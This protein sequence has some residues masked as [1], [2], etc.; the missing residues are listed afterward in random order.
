MLF[1]QP[2]DRRDIGATIS[3]SWFSANGKSTMS[4]LIVNLL[5]SALRFPDRVAVRLD[6][7]VL[8]YAQLGEHAARV[9]A[10]LR[11][12]GVT[13]GSRVPMMLP[14]VPEFVVLYCGNLRAGCVVVPMNPLLKTREVADYL[15]NA[16]ARLLFDR[17]DAAL[18]LI[19]RFEPV[20]FDAPVRD[21]VTMFA[22]VPTMYTALLHDPG[23]A[24]ADVA[25]LRRYAS[26][27]ASAGANP[28]HV[29]F[30]DELPTGPTGKILDRAITRP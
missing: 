28:R 2:W 11:A 23:A 30:L 29:W 14:N 6:D 3:V 24:T 9:I 18:T 16:G 17:R 15:A 8:T 5:Q 22:G 26:G 21:R 19:P 25:S 10:V 12:E 13:P 20:V 1:P 4:A 27:G 7:T